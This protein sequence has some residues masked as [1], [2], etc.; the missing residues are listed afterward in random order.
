VD[1]VSYFMLRL[2]RTGG[3]A[4]A[5]AV[6]G[7]V[8]H[9]STGEKRTFGNAG[10]LIELLLAWSDPPPSKLHPGQDRSNAVVR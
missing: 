4:A 10:E 3:A 2:R 5:A 9:L 6:A 8:Q 1:H 7:T